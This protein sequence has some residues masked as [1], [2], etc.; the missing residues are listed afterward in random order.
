MAVVQYSAL[1]TQLR[2]K[3][4]GSQF[5]RGHSVQTLQ[6]KSTPT[7]RQTPAQI[8]QRQRVGVAQRA[9]KAETDQRRSEASQ[10]ALSNPVYNRLGQQVVLSAYNHY[11]KM[12]SWRQLTNSSTQPTPIAQS[13]ITTPVAFMQVEVSNFVLDIG[14][15]QASGGYGFTATFERSLTGAETGVTN[16]NRAYYY[17]TPVMP[18]GTRKRGARPVFLFWGA[19]STSLSVSTSQF[20]YT[21]QVFNSGD[22]VFLEVYSRNTGAGAETGYFSEVIQLQ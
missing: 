20:F 15:F 13:I 3:L 17:I 11:I 2:G 9:W 14:A 19:V 21:S 4:G 5:N 6:R 12:M 8:R 1:V 7:V 16:Q 18:D 22:Y 10:A